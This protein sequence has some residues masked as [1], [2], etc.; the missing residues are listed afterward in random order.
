[1]TYFVLV[2]TLFNSWQIIQKFTFVDVKL[3]TIF[4]NH[5]T[6]PLLKVIV[7]PPFFA[8]ATEKM[9]YG[10]EGMYSAS[11]SCAL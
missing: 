9:S 7:A 4:G 2:N 11:L 3:A 5:L 1:M 10:Y 8:L 6:V